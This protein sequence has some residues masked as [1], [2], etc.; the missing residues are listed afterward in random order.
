LFFFA[1][2]AAPGGCS[3][4]DEAAVAAVWPSTRPPSWAGAGR[5]DTDI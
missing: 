2:F 4:D 5:L 1:E 3:V